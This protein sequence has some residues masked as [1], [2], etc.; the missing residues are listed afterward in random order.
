MDE[1]AAS[2]MRKG[3]SVKDALDQHCEGSRPPRSA[4]IVVAVL[5]ERSMDVRQLSADVA[6]DA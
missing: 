5:A 3:S 2:Q 1:E 6:G 4:I